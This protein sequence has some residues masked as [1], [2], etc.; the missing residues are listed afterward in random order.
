[1]STLKE[2]YVEILQASD[3]GKDSVGTFFTDGS[4]DQY[5]EVLRGVTKN[6][7]V[8]KT[9]LS[10][11]TVDEGT[12]PFIL[13]ANNENSWAIVLKDNDK[14][15]INYKEQSP[16][17]VAELIRSL[18]EENPESNVM[19][20]TFELPSAE[21]SDD[22][23]RSEY[24]EFFESVKRG[25]KGSENKNAQIYDYANSLHD[26]ARELGLHVQVV[27]TEEWR[28][29][30]NTFA[31]CFFYN[32]S[33]TYVTFNGTDTFTFRSD[34]SVRSEEKLSLA[35]FVEQYTRIRPWNKALV[36]TPDEQREIPE[37]PPEPEVVFAHL[38]KPPTIT[39]EQLNQ[40]LDGRSFLEAFQIDGDHRVFFR[41]QDVN[42][43][44]QDKPRP[45]NVC[46]LTT[47]LNFYM[48]TL[49]ETQ[50]KFAMAQIN[51]YVAPEYLLTVAEGNDE[52]NEFTSQICSEGAGAEGL[53]LLEI[54]KFLPDP[55]D[56]EIS[57][58]F[59]WRSTASPEELTRKF[60]MKNFLRLTRKAQHDLLLAKLKDVTAIP[61]IKMRIDKENLLP[62]SMNHFVV[63][64]LAANA[65]HIIDNLRDSTRE[66][67]VPKPTLFMDWAETSLVETDNSTAS[68]QPINN[69]VADLGLFDQ[70]AFVDL[71]A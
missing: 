17:D 70:T 34:G 20:F 19:Y 5:I 64:V 44:E 26:R 9:Q 46:P 32:N 48:A 68:I 56:I 6:I 55:E 31:A 24:F 3:L 18:K 49:N 40:T 50:T 53:K 67:E 57:R 61:L 71:V 14:Y 59:K 22:E 29:T 27:D 69:D 39:L 1:M 38:G 52:A 33:W 8:K 66:G 65:V 60:H 2:V 23:A 30:D 45:A 42:K 11:I 36:F 10:E 35:T 13:C 43:F 7:D 47:V 21:V 62:Y 54:I 37:A 16:E 4:V 28:F 12:P 51:S 15:F 58:Q 25:L 41:Y 63:A